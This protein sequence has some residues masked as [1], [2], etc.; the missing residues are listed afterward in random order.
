[1]QM[2]GKVMFLRRTHP[3]CCDEKDKRSERFVPKNKK[4][5]KKKNLAAF[6]IF[7]FFF[8]N[9]DKNTLTHNAPCKR[10]EATAKKDSYEIQLTHRQLSFSPLALIPTFP[11]K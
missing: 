11:M 2:R 8:S 3:C 5:E 9:K 10:G 7:A 4:K 1:M 6:I